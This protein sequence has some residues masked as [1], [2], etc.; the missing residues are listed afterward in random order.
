MLKIG[1]R[2]DS[3]RPFLWLPRFISSSQV[4]KQISTAFILLSLGWQASAAGIEIYSE[5]DSFTR[6]DPVTING[7]LNE[8]EG[9]FYE[10][11]KQYSYNQAEFGF[12]KNHWGL[13]FLKRLDY[14]I[15]FSDETA[16][17]VYLTQ[18]KLD[19]SM[20]QDVPLYFDVHHFQGSGMRLSYR[21]ETA[22]RFN[23]EVGLSYLKGERLTEGNVRGNLTPL[24][25]NDYDFTADIDYFY[26]ADDLFDRVVTRP[27]GQGYSIDLKMDYQ[28]TERLNLEAKIQD[29]WA[30]IYWQNAPF[31]QA[32]ASSDTKHFDEDGYVH[33]D[34]HLQG[35]ESQRDFRQ[36]LPAKMKFSLN[37]K[38]SPSTQAEI[39]YW[40][41]PLDGYYALAL[42]RSW[43]K[44]NVSV[45]YWP[46]LGS[47][48]LGLEFGRL[49]L[50]ITSDQLDFKEARTL[51]V[52][53]A[54]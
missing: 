52:N 51:G 25:R 45:R 8:W 14:Q 50:T 11:N 29:A 10:G 39:N 36:R 27:Q 6:S 35:I 46:E 4:I 13:G 20:N 17:A 18:N 12:R 7:A 2:G 34:S 5:F 48:G 49:S 31:T 26:S 1:H 22:S 24:S 54:F 47:V 32:S 19:L 30:E 41:L 42:S 43:K 28:I 40:R 15:K 38:I 9:E 23:F 21:N 37:Q 33:F 44:N 3:S 16:R 53:I